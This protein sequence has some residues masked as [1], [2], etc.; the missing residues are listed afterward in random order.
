MAE[1]TKISWCRSTHN[2]WIGC[3]K[4]S[5]GCDHCYAEVSRPSQTFKIK[6]GHGQPRHRISA[7]SVKNVLTWNRKAAHERET[8]R[9]ML[10]DTWKGAP[11]FWPVFPSLCDPFDNE[12]PDAWRND[13][14]S[15]IA[16]T[17]NLTW[18]LLTKRI[19][20]AEAMLPKGWPR[21]KVWIGAS[22]VDQNEADRDLPKLLALEGFGKR[23]VSYEPALGPVD[24]SDYFEQFPDHN[25]VRIVQRHNGIDWLIIGG[26]SNQGG[27]KAR[28]FQVKWARST[29]SQCRA[30]AVPVFVKQL[31]ANIIIRN[32]EEFDDWPTVD[33]GAI[34][35]NVHGYQENHQGADCRI[36]LESR[37][38]S[39]PAEWPEDLRIQQHP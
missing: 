24:F 29:V 35:H 31:G 3:T 20:N 22:V 7:T 39:D 26:E 4:V 13:F 8:G 33:L 5:P 16:E 36:F 37:A 12:V 19:G 28:P 23:F 10:P 25:G 2:P 30:A 1:T 34:E 32:D 38:G 15:L 9:V 27:H 11:G 18:L 21:G 14:F 17:P 6:W